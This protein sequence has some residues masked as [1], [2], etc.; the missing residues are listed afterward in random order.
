M[1]GIFRQLFRMVGLVLAAGLA[2]AMLVRYSQGA[3]VD[4]REVNQRLR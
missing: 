3:L 2:S 4:Q 1:K